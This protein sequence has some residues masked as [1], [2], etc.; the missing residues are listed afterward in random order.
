MNY[1]YDQKVYVFD[2][3]NKASLVLAPKLSSSENDVLYYG[4]DLFTFS[5][6]S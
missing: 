5:E 6:M 3:L 4:K 1:T 2:I